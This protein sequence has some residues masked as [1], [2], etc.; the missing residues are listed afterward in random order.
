MLLAWFLIH[1]I[2]LTPTH[3]L[4]AMPDAPISKFYAWD[5][6][7]FGATGWIYVHLFSSIFFI[8]MYFE[9]LDILKWKR[10]N[11]AEQG[12]PGYPPQSVGSPDP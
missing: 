9:F 10:K 5:L 7:H 12:G 8:G 2:L 11:E 1:G 4:A 3:Y 6:K